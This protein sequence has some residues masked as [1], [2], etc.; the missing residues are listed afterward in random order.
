MEDYIPKTQQR[1]I[2]LLL[3]WVNQI[4]ISAS[5]GLMNRALTTKS[6]KNHQDRSRSL[7][8]VSTEPDFE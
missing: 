5:E 1:A 6:V 3:I 7:E 2:D 8:Q 4:P